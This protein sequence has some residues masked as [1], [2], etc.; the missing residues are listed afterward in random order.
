MT[1]D[2]MEE[3]IATCVNTE[4]VRRDG[5]SYYHYD[6]S[7]TIAADLMAMVGP[8]KLVWGVGSNIC[9]CESDPRYSLAYW[10]NDKVWVDKYTTMRRHTSSKLAKAAAQAHHEAKHWENTV[11]GG[12]DD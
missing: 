12:T 5:E 7:R 1:N 8:K 3:A 9:T 2:E 11:I 10:P 4:L 6:L